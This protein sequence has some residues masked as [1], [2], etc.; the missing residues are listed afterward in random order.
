MGFAVFRVLYLASL[1]CQA[2]HRTTQSTTST[3]K[4]SMLAVGSTSNITGASCMQTYSIVMISS[5]I[6][7]PRIAAR[8]VHRSESNIASIPSSARVATTRH[9]MSPLVARYGV[10]KLR[11]LTEHYWKWL[12]HGVLFSRSP[13]AAFTFS[14]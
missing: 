8:L 7:K 13:L 2:V 11:L 6:P 14:V 5:R 3:C 10:C 12:Y 4:P 1:Y 9:H